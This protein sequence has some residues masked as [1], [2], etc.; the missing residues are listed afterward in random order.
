MTYD[1]QKHHAVSS[2]S[3]VT[4]IQGPARISS[5]SA[6]TAPADAT[7]RKP[8]GRLIGAF[9]TVST[10]HIHEMRNTPGAVVWQR[11]YYEHVMRAEA[12]LDRIRRYI[13]GNP[14]RWA[15]DE[16]HPAH[17]PAARRGI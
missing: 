12:D 3:R 17:A 4:I 6:R 8:L 14:A 7:K 5:P 16:N 15:E 2:A 13:V 1:P 11:N 9:K 10:K